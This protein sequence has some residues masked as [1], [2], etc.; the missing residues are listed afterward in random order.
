MQIHEKLGLLLQF[1]T[2]KEAVSKAFGEGLAF[3]YAELDSVRLRQ[4]G[5]CIVRGIKCVAN[6]FIQSMGSSK[7]MICIAGLSVAE[8]ALPGDIEFLPINELIKE[9]LTVQVRVNGP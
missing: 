1:W 5:G 9:V 4:E 7:Y 2:S 3:P 8:S 6:Q